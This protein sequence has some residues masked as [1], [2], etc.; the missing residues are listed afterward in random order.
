MSMLR[1]VQLLIA[2]IPAAMA[3]QEP[4]SAQQIGDG[5]Q[6]HQSGDPSPSSQTKLVTLV[7][8]VAK[9]ET[10]PG[11]YT[12]VESKGGAMY[13]LSG[14]DMHSY[15]GHEVQVTGGPRRFAV[16]FGLVPSPN[17]AAQAGAVDQPPAAA[18]GTPAAGHAPLPEFRVRSVK[19]TTGTCA[20]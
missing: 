5:S 10:A 2:F 1:A 3:A 9:D 15:I 20:K 7:G 6:H 12:F 17:A 19:T 4:P 13:K 18:A 16:G 14:T 8:C 11:Q